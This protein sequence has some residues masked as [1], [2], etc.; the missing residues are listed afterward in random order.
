MSLHNVTPGAKAP[1]E[2]DAARD[3]QHD[4]HSGD[5]HD[6]WS[7]TLRDT[8]HPQLLAAA[9]PSTASVTIRTD[10]PHAWSAQRF[11]TSPNR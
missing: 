11:G 1:D 5:G 3:Q 2:E 8:V 10:E 7:V 6:E 9:E 4:E